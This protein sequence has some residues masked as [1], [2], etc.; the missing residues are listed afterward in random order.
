M[1]VRVKQKKNSHKYWVLKH[2]EDFGS[3]T[4]FEAFENYGITRLSAV[5]FNLRKEGHNIDSK[6]LSVTNRYGKVVYFHKYQL[7]E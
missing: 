4:S 2:L 6:K 3:L 1:I 7:E 5:I